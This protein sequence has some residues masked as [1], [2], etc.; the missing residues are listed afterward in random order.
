M[1]AQLPCEHGC[2][3]RAFRPRRA[4]RPLQLLM[5]TPLL[6]GAAKVVTSPAETAGAALRRA[7]A[8]SG[9][10]TQALPVFCFRRPGARRRRAAADRTTV[11]RGHAQRAAACER[12]GASAGRSRLTPTRQRAQATGTP[13]RTRTWQPAPLSAGRRSASRCG[14]A[15][16]V[17]SAAASVPS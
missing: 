1:L 17:T 11:T 12:A 5:S 4:K 13:P 2:S 3:V 9:D 16:V 10:A 7:S 15:R 8:G 6:A 14:D